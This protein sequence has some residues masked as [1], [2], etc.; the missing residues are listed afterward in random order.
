MDPAEIGY[1]EAQGLQFFKSLVERVKEMPG[2]ESASL[3]TAVPLGY[4]SSAD[5]LKIEGFSHR[6]ARLSRSLFSP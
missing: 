1:N 5:T 6:Q 4:F 3:T 2:V